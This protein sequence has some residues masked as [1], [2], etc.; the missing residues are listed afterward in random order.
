MVRTP[1]VGNHWYKENKKKRKRKKETEKK[2]D[3]KT[4]TKIYKFWILMK[5]LEIKCDEILGKLGEKTINNA[6]FLNM[7]KNS[8]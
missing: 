7:K 5:S 6:F 4:N 2:M 8:Y 1:H 3:K